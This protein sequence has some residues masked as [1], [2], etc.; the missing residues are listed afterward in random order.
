MQDKTIHSTIAAILAVG[1][2][3]LSTA[4]LAE[5]TNKPVTAVT[6]KG[7]EKCYGIVKAGMNDCGTATNNGCS[8]NSTVDGDKS[9]WIYLPKGTCKKIV[10]SSTKAPAAEST[11]NNSTNTNNNV[12]P[13]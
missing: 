7:M 11:T 9:A 1:V 5:S 13:S 6:P 10:G 4:S 3:S 8:G 2:A 12:S